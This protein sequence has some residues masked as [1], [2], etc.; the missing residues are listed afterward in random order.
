MSNISVG[1]W[2]VFRNEDRN[3]LMALFSL[4]DKDEPFFV[5]DV[6]NVHSSKINFS[7]NGKEEFSFESVYETRIIVETIHNKRIKGSEDDPWLPIE[8]FELV[9]SFR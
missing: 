3:Q 8:Y 4:S 1:D 2:V 6:T 7:Q 9:K 5:I